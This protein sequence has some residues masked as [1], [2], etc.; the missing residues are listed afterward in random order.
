MRLLLRRL[1]GQPRRREWRP[2]RR[3]GFHVAEA[4][5][6]GLV[7]SEVRAVRR[8][9]LVGITGRRREAAHALRAPSCPRWLL[10]PRPSPYGWRRAASRGEPLVDDDTR[11]SQI[12]RSMPVF[13]R[14]SAYPTSD[15]GGQS[16]TP[17]RMDRRREPATSAD[18]PASEFD[19]SP[20]TARSDY[21]PTLGGTLRVPR[22]AAGSAGSATSAMAAARSRPE[23]TTRTVRTVHPP[24]AAARRRLALLERLE[25]GPDLPF[26]G[27][28]TLPPS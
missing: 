5:A 13:P 22:A 15:P 3:A 2:R 8:G 24:S 11:S 26:L 28:R 17:T 4:M 12:L 1:I 25:R 18:G 6:A 14:S 16:E 9:L 7:G 20:V 21:S 23:A 27:S 19:G 10:R